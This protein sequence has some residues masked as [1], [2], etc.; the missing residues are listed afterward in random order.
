MRLFGGNWTD[1]LF[2]LI[3]YNARCFSAPNIG[4][5][6]HTPQRQTSSRKKRKKIVIFDRTIPRL[7]PPRL[8]HLSTS[9]EEG[10]P[11]PPS[12]TY[13]RFFRM[14]NRASK[15]F[16]F[17]K[18]IGSKTEQNETPVTGKTESSRRGWT[19]PETSREES[20]SR[21][22]HYLFSERRAANTKERR[23]LTEGH[24]AAG[25]ITRR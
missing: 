24:V 8:Y 9:E 13:S 3:V 23:N 6:P 12:P 1:L 25:R 20:K 10:A 7:A 2:S 11:P 4:C 14:G 19:S 17:P 18:E 22:K 16:R 21:K 15:H 5:A